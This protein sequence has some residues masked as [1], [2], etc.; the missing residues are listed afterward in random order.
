MEVYKDKVPDYTDESEIYPQTHRDR[1]SVTMELKEQC[2]QL[3]FLGWEQAVKAVLDELWDE[4]FFDTELVILKNILEIMQAEEEAMEE[5]EQ[6]FLFDC[7]S[8]QQA[9]EK[10]LSVKF[11]LRREKYAEDD[12]GICTG[13]TEAARKVIAGHTML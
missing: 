2:K 11:F 3:L 1:F 13:I 5:P 9:Y 8:F 6:R 12:T 4:R 7:G 10:Y